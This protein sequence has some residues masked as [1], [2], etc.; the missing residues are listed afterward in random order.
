MTICTTHDLDQFVGAM[1]SRYP[2][3][4]TLANSRFLLQ[5]TREHNEALQ[6]R[7]Q[8]SRPRRQQQRYARPVYNRLTK[9]RPHINPASLPW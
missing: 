7:Y 1:E 3:W 4:V 6:R 9:A 2:V 8:D 5:L